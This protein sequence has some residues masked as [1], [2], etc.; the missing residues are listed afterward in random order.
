MTIGS[1][2]ERPELLQ[3]VE[4]GHWQRL[5]DHFAGVLG[6]SLRTVSPSRQLLVAPSWPP[7]FPAEGV[8][9]TLR[10]GD[11]LEHLLPAAKLPKD[12]SSITIPLGVTYAAVPVRATPER[13]IAYLVVGPMVVGSRESRTQFRQR[14]ASLTSDVQAVWNLILALKVFTFSGIRSLLNLL[15]EV[16]TSLVQ[17]AYQANQLAKLLP[18]A[19]QADQADTGYYTDRVIQSLLEVATMATRADGGSVMMREGDGNILRIKAAVGLTDEIV[20]RTSQDAD[21]G[22]AGFAM[23]QRAPLVL[24]EKTADEAARPLMRRQ[25]LVSSMLAPIVLEPD[26]QPVGVLNLR[27]SDA[28]RRFTP[29][30]IEMVR[31][32]L[33]MT[34]VAL[35]NLRTAFSRA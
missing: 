26:Q 24:D 34:S 2:A 10:V 12:A 20:T 8:I 35:G 28:R 21:S 4:A 15:E 6:I 11:E 32:L 18:E 30:H 3:L 9:R 23:S 13:I 5:Q 31:R 33:E 27:T 22:L 16:G 25:E 7:G 14:A 29:D 1:P 19:G 17:F